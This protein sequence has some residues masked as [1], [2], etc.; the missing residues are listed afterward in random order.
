MPV[1]PTYPGVYVQELPSGNRTII[2]VAT[3][4]GAIAGTFP[5]GPANVAIPA[6][7][8]GDFERDFGGLAAAFETTYQ[9]KQFFLNGGGQMLVV[10]VA[11]GATP[12]AATINHNDPGGAAEALLATAGRSV[13]GASVQ[14]PGA[15]GNNIR[16]DVDHDAL[17]AAGFN[18]VVSEIRTENGRE[19]VV[20]TETFRNLVMAAGPAN[21]I[22]T[23]NAGSRMIQLSRQAAW[24]LTR[25]AATGTVSAVVNVPGLAGTALAN[26]LTVTIGG[27]ASAVV[28]PAFA[29]A[30]TTLA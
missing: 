5:R 19:A 18:M 28:V 7:N 6:F 2:G 4:I 10:R 8:P 21:A 11:P 14:D 30:P 9:V 16:I 3:S 20:R 17:G 22:D 12:A 29:A 23:V 24:L 13:R 1:S 27:V 25:P 26:T 15:W